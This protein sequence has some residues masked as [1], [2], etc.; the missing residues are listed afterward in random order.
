[1]G[2]ALSYCYGVPS[3]IIVAIADLGR[4]AL[5]SI[6]RIACSGVGIRPVTA[7]RHLMKSFTCASETQGRF[8]GT[9]RRWR[10]ELLADLTTSRRLR[11][12]NRGGELDHQADQAH[13][14]RHPQTWTTPGCVCCGTAADAT[15]RSS[16]CAPQGAPTLSHV[17]RP[18]MAPHT[19]PVESLRGP[20]HGIDGEG[21]WHSSDRW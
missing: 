15:A 16:R 6:R 1:M 18:G 17:R 3:P 5:A 19:R 4:T 20:R 12:T 2:A 8:A 7:A 14:P 21:L 9:V 10:A 11:R 13:R